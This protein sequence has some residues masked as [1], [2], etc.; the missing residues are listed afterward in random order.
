MLAQMGVRFSKELNSFFKAIMATDPETRLS[1]EQALKHIWLNN[2]GET[3]MSGPAVVAE[4]ERRSPMKRTES[5]TQAVEWDRATPMDSVIDT[6]ERF[7]RNMGKTCTVGNQVI[8]EYSENGTDDGEEDS[9]NSITV[10]CEV[11]SR[12]LCS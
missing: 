7:V 4:M 5:Q 6:I 3:P 11:C 1:A 9:Q 8:V 2:P 10:V 12:I